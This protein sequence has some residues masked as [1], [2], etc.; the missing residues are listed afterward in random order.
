MNIFVK[1]FTIYAFDTKNN[2]YLDRYLMLYCNSYLYK[3]LE[4]GIVIHFD[5]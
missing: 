3:M 2:D 1:Q 4:T 5:E